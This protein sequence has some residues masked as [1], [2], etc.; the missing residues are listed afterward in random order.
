VFIPTVDG[1]K[2]TLDGETYEEAPEFCQICGKHNP[3]PIRA[4]FTINPNVEL[5]GEA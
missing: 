4:T 2:T 1:G 3:E 5:T